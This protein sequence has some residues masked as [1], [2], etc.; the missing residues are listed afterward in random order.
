LQVEH[1][2]EEKVAAITSGSPEKTYS[3]SVA[4]VLP[5]AANMTTPAAATIGKTNGLSRF[6]TTCS[7]DPP[8]WYDKT[9]S[10]A[11]LQ[12]VK[13]ARARFFWRAGD[14]PID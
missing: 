13:S 3:A 9:P 1:Q 10:D 11:S 6:I 5:N 8:L 14:S 4:D 2:A 12:P 7:L